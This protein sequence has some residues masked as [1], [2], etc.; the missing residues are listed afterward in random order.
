MRNEHLIC[1][2]GICFDWNW[3][4]F[5]WVKIKFHTLAIE[6]L[7]TLFC[8]HTPMRDDIDLAA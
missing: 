4:N 3:H 7:L 6:G 8:P 5:D 2:A 1:L